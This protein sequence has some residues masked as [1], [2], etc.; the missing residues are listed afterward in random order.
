MAVFSDL[1]KF[2]KTY[3]IGVVPKKCGIGSPNMVQKRVPQ[4]H[5]FGGATLTFFQGN[6]AKKSKSFE[7]RNI[8]A[9]TTKTV[10]DT[11]KRTKF[12]PKGSYFWVFTL[13]TIRRSLPYTLFS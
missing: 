12:R 13:R 4:L 7:N 9:A 3:F 10:R 8:F 1:L 2:D 6:A 11:S 5:V